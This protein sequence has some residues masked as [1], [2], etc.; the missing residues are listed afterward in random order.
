M[1]KCSG[2]CNQGRLPCPTPELCGEEAQRRRVYWEDV[3]VATLAAVFVALV[4][5]G[6]L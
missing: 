3:V 6:V 4:W 2:P 1:V 5:L